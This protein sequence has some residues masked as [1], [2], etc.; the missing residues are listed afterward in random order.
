MNSSRHVLNGLMDVNRQLHVLLRYVEGWEQC[1]KP[2]HATCSRRCSAR[3]SGL[4]YCSPCQCTSECLGSLPET[5]CLSAGR[6]RILLVDEHL[7][8]LSSSLAFNARARVSPLTFTAFTFYGNRRIERREKGER[9]IESR[10]LY[11]CTCS[12]ITRS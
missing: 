1:M 8:S 12:S 4:P 2:C 7:P 11:S 9:E 10:F 3:R 6:F 5:D